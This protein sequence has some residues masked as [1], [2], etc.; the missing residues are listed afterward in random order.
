MTCPLDLLFDNKSQRCEYI[1]QSNQYHHHHQQQQPQMQPLTQPRMASYKQIDL[2]QNNHL[3]SSFLTDYLNNVNK[4]ALLSAKL[5]STSNA[6]QH[7]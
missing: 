2:N 3:N 5:N 1:H 7:S 6:D 4:E